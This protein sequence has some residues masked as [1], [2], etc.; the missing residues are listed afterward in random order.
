MAFLRES[1]ELSEMLVEFES[2]IAKEGTLPYN[3]RKL[4][5]ERLKQMGLLIT[6]KRKR[7]EELRNQLPHL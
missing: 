3:E 4:H 1:Y 7:V 2:Q 5:Q 6:E